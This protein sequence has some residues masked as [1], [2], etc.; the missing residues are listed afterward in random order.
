M[1]PSCT[2]ETADTWSPSR[3]PN[4]GLIGRG[5]CGSSSTCPTAYVPGNVGDPCD[6]DSDCTGMRPVC[7]A[8]GPSGKYPG[9]MCSSRGCELGSNL[10]CPAGDT[11]IDGGSDTYC[12]EGCGIDQDNCFV[13]CPRDGYACFNTES[14]TMGFCMGE[15]GVRECNPAAGLACSDPGFGA[16]LCDQVSW[17][18]PTVGQCF[19]TCDPIAQDCSNS[20][21][22]CYVVRD[23][24][25]PICYENWGFD[26]G[27]VCT[28]LTHCEEGLTCQCDFDDR[29]LCPNNSNMHCRRYCSA[30][31]PC[32][33]GLR[34]RI[35]ESGVGACIP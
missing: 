18:D 7:L 17:D 12:L 35:I 14:K 2:D 24:E 8:S 34:C 20:L 28:R 23:V 25:E 26:E 9:G 29:S 30:A 1:P 19:E 5:V 33:S 6:A 32:P 31:A 13:H 4:G 16:G 15:A 27:A 21:H 11:C 10:G 22:G 3:G